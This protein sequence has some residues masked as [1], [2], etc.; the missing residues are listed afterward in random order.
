[1]K[2]KIIGGPYMC[3]G[4][5]GQNSKKIWKMPRPRQEEIPPRAIIT[6]LDF[7]FNILGVR[8]SH[9]IQILGM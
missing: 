8:L 1:M 2:T 5:Y 9:A 7:K 3:T 6:R 4:L